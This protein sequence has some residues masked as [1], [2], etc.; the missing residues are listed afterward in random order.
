MVISDSRRDM[1]GPKECMLGR[2]GVREGV[3]FRDS[4]YESY[5][6]S[7]THFDSPK[8]VFVMNLRSHFG[9]YL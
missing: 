9:S 2:K 7:F 3:D 6:Q 5:K 1:T 4:A 8:S